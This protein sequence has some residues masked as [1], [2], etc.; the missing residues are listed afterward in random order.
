MEL[1][2]IYG[3][4]RE[5]IESAIEKKFSDDWAV[6]SGDYM[7]RFEKVVRDNPQMFPLLSKY[8]R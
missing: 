5:A 7:A 1:A 8:Y 6:S 3:E 4:Q 2:R